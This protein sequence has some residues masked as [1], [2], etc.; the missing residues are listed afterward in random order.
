MMIYPIKLLNEIKDRL[1]HSQHTIAVAESVTSGHLQAAFSLADEATFFYQGGITA[2]NLGQKSRHLLVEPIHAVKNNCVSA[3]IACDMAINVSRLFVSHYGVGITGYAATIP[4]E[5]I[6]DL[7]AFYAI[8]LNGK[9]VHQAKI[10]ADK[11][12]MLDAQL[13]YTEQVL[14]GLYSVLQAN[15]NLV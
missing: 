13:Y 14:N 6:N 5:G 2:Y 4:E 11:S 12:S 8:S 15:S 3:P 9:I 10:T 1:I 7:F